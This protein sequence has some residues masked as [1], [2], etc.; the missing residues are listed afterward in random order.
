MEDQEKIDKKILEEALRQVLK[1]F[2]EFI[3][4]CMKN[5]KQSIKDI[6]RARA[7]LPSWCEN[8]HK[9]MR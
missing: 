8:S 9:V 1:N 2:D 6:A 7:C 4:V 3:G 5:G